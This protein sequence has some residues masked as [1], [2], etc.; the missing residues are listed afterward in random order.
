MLKTWIIFR[1]FSGD[2]YEGVDEQT[3]WDLC[4]IKIREMSILCSKMKAKNNKNDISKLR[5]RLNEVDK[6]LAQDPNDSR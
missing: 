1:W 5:E 2:G 3:K 4:K 6:I